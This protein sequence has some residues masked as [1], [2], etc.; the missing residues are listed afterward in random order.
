MVDKKQIENEISAIKAELTSTATN[1]KPVSFFSRRSLKDIVAAI[2]L[3]LASRQT[4]REQEQS[5]NDFSL[6]TIGVAGLILIAGP[7]RGSTDI[8]WVDENAF[9]FVVFGLVACTWF[10]L[11]S[12]ERAPLF[13]LLAKFVSVRITAGFLFASGIAVATSGANTALNAVLGVDAVN[14]PL[15]RAFLVAALFLKLL[16][17]VFLLLGAIAVINL[18]SVFSYVRWKGRND[19]RDVKYREFPVIEL[20]FV[21]VAV[22][23]SAIY[24]KTTT[25]I[26]SEANLP[27]KAYRL[28]LQLDFNKSVYCFQGQPNERYLFIGGNQDKVLIAPI[29]L[30]ELS[31]K[32]FA[33]EDVTGSEDR[34]KA[35]RIV[36]CHPQL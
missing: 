26:F 10:I 19:D 20:V 11:M 24:V 6:M 15:A 4:A 9:W 17:P 22:V 34:L 33:T 7:G 28:A 29:P 35:I 25:R 18:L 8:A 14:A 27:E 32:G 13:S 2:H 23:F 3:Q 5:A 21:L 36:G 31:W 30:E 16:W 1:G 12:L